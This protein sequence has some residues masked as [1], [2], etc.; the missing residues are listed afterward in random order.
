MRILIFE[1]DPY[2]FHVIKH[3]LEELEPESDIM[4]PLSSVEQG[5]EFFQYEQETD[6]IIADIQLKDGLCFDALRLAPQNIPIIFTTA[7]KEHALKAFEFFSLSFLIKPIVKEEL[8]V[9]LQKAK[10]LNA[11]HSTLNSTS[12]L[13]SQRGAYRERLVVKSAKR[14]KIILLANTKYIFSEDKVTYIKLLDGSSYP[15]DMTL[16]NLANQLSP[17]KFMRVNRKYILPIE[18]VSYT[19]RL[20]NGKMSIHVKGEEDTLIIVSRT[21][22]DEVCKWLNS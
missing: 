16:E 4:G 12:T 21:R 17:R 18:Q 6:I 5:R 22:K 3:L 8:E 10:S 13:N 1:D 14:D 19:E 15:I 2:Y 20:E 11:Q 7:H 9:A